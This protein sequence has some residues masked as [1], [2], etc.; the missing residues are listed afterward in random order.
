[1][2][3]I[4]SHKA[5]A[6]R[7]SF[8]ISA[9]SKFVLNYCIEYEHPLG[10]GN[11]SSVYRCTKNTQPN[12]KYAVKLL[13]IAHL[14]QNRLEHLVRTEIELLMAINHQHVI[15]CRDVFWSDTWCYIFCDFFEG[16]LE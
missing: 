9:P 15:T 11:F 12:K 7:S 10:K 2:I 1:M 6:L 14:R 4:P 8:N 3:V 16:N 13:N 5:M